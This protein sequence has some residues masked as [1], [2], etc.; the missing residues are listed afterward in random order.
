MKRYYIMNGNEKAS[1]VEYATKELAESRREIMQTWESNKDATLEVV[2][3]EIP[4]I[5]VAE[6]VKQ[7]LD[8]DV[9]DN[10]CEELWIAFCGDNFWL[11]PEG[12]E[13]FADVLEYPVVLHDSLAEIII[14]EGADNLDEDDEVWNKRLARAKKFFYSAAG[15][16]DEDDY[17]LWFTNDYEQSA[18]GMPS[19]VDP[20]NL[21]RAY[22]QNRDGNVT[23]ETTNRGQVY[24]SLAGELIAKKMNACTY[25]KR[26]K[27]TQNYDGTVTITV[28]YADDCGGGKRVYTIIG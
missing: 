12:V 13:E 5:T 28:Y 8:I 11:T 16:C 6:L 23:W 24:E 15:Y 10:V 9:I 21:I 2:E 22:F 17:D 14:D 7:N 26:I 4:T 25:I 3:V 19:V 27:R 18:E 1:L 20:C